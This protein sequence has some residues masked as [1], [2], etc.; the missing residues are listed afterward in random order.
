MSD[1][2]EWKNKRNWGRVLVGSLAAFVVISIV[3][4]GLLFWEGHQRQQAIDALAAANKTK[5]LTVDTLCKD[6][7]NDPVCKRAEEAPSTS[8]ILEDPEVQ[9][10]E[11]NDP[12]IQDPEIQDRENQQAERQDPENQDPEGQ[13]PEAQDADPD[14]PEVNDPDPDDP[15]IQDPEIQ[16]PEIDD[17][18][19]NSAITFEASDSCNPPAGDVV[20]DVGITVSRG[21]GTVTYTVTCQTTTPPATPG[22]AFVRR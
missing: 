13:D 15:E 1:V 17:P 8:E 11:V 16:D 7:P 12:E 14:D 6:T 9:D 19:P 21:N 4:W 3:I 10:P 2:Q 20:T 18:D 22:A 5:D